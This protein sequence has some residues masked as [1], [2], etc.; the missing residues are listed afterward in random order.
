VSPAGAPGS[1][2]ALVASSGS[3]DQIYLLPL[4]DAGAGRSIALLQ[5]P[6]AGARLEVGVS[7]AFPSG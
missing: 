6:T 1:L 2:I 7:D 4:V 3:E 5:P